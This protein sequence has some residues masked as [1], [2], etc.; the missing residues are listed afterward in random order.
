ML[1]YTIDYLS[2]TL[3]CFLLTKN[4]NNL[5]L[6]FMIPNKFFNMLTEINQNDSA[7]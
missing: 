5:Q 4:L 2:Q 7:T 1:L 3:L 6:Q